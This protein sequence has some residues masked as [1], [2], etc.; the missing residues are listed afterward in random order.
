MR[1]RTDDPRAMD[2]SAGSRTEPGRPTGTRPNG[3]PRRVVHEVAHELVRPA[4]LRSLRTEL[5]AWLRAA[6]A[7]PE[8]PAFADRL[9]DVASSLYE[10]LTNVVDHAYTGGPGP[11]HLV[12]RLT[13]ADGA[14]HDPGE[15]PWLEIVVADRGDWRP[16]A[17]DPGHRGRGLLLLS[18]V[19]DGH[20]VERGDDGTRVRWW[21]HRPP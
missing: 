20:E 9:E 18:Q 21:W 17:D 2:A 12:A 19:T 14:E 15:H 13:L 11:I 3:S 10:A 4:D 5:V 1:H 8:T 7:Q 16:A 6:A